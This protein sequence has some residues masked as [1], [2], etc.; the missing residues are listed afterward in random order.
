[1]PI[2]LWMILAGLSALSLF[3]GL[4]SKTTQPP[5]RRPHAARAP[6]KDP[7]GLFNDD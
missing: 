4:V 1:M 3:I 5:P 6:D 2:P 7:L